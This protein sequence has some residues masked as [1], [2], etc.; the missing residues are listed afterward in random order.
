MFRSD[1]DIDLILIGKTGNGKSSTG[2]SILNKKSFKTSA[3]RHSCTTSFEQDSCIYKGKRTIKVVDTMGIDNNRENNEGLLTFINKMTEIFDEKSSGYHAFVLVFR[4]GV[5]FTNEEVQTITILKQIFGE[6]FLKEFGI[7][8]MTCGDNFDQEVTFEKWCAEQTGYFR[9]LVRECRENI[10]LFNNKRTVDDDKK[11]EK[12]VEK[13]INMID[14]LNHSRKRYTKQQFEQAKLGRDKL[15][16]Q[17]NQSII[18]EQYNK[19]FEP[20]IKQL[21]NTFLD[22]PE[23]RIKVLKDLKQKS[24][25]ILKF[26][27]ESGEELVILND[28]INYARVAV[29]SINDQLFCTVLFVEILKEKEIGKSLKQTVINYIKEM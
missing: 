4:F 12:Q 21:V 25:C 26:L 18:K 14:S 11:R 1:R 28:L 7:I 16:M 5:R 15:L 29:V 17:M 3:G 6:S 8:I 10:I 13:L 19:Q 27:F 20:I 2:N 22:E 23:N 9:D 24:I